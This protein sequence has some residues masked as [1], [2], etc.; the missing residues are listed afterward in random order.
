MASSLRVGR[1]ND[2]V[3]HLLHKNGFALDKIAADP[4]IARHRE[5]ADQDKRFPGGYGWR[6]PPAASANCKSRRSSLGTRR[7]IS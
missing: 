7:R 1:V 4:D 2:D 6:S 3:N 5:F